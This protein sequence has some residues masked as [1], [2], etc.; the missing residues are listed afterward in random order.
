MRFGVLISLILWPVLGMGETIRVVDGDTL[1]YGQEK[2][3][4]HGIDAPELAQTCGTWKC[5][6]ASKAFLQQL[7]AGQNVHCHAQGRD[8]YDRLIAACRTNNGD[9]GDAMVSNGYAWAFVKYS[10]DYKDQEARAKR[11]RV[12]IWQQPSL[13]AWDYR[14]A[15]W[16]V[17]QQKAPKGC[18]I[19]GN[20]SR[21]GKIYHTPWSQWYDR[22]K[23]SQNKGERWFCNEA[24]AIAAGW[25]PAQ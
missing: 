3:R 15:K 23:I 6:E 18:P 12:G 14:A 2:I 10:D 4:L 5:G 17:S 19:K 13:P 16:T 24:E 21:N 20:I 25:R 7:V 8:G 22:T 9:I 11:K 1:I